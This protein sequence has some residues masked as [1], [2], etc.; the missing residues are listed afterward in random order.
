MIMNREPNTLIP[1]RVTLLQRLKSW[2]DQE[3]WRDF[4]QIYW[5]LIYAVALRA[6]LNDAEAQDVVQETIITVARKM[7]SFRYDPKVDSFKGWLLY[8]TRKRIAMHYRRRSRER[9]HNC[10]N[11]DTAQA[12]VGLEEIPDVS[13]CSEVV[14]EEEWERN[15]LEA[16]LAR[17]KSKVNARQYQMFDLYVNRQW[18]VRQVAE[19][20][21]VQA[22][23]VYLAKHR[24]VAL[25]K[26][27]VKR[28]ERE[29][30]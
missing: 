28:L 13:A 3:S 17:I 22:A 10:G 21:G 27:E 7:G 2:D 8:I 29:L 14:W 20:L 9:G 15:L 24:I 4:F 6:G 23:Q 5:K 19:T 1:T 18:P 16:A 26:E 25:V 11:S 30:L 12:S